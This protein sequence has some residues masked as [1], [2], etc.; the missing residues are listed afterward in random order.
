MQIICKICGNIFEACQYEVNRGRKFCSLKCFSLSQHKRIKKTCPSCKKIFEVP[1]CESERRKFCSIQCRKSY[2]GKQVF[3]ASC[4]KDFRVLNLILKMG[5]GKFCSQKCYDNYRTNETETKY[6]S[7][8]G[9]QYLSRKSQPR[10]F[11]SQQCYWDDLSNRKYPTN[12][13]LNQDRIVDILEEQGCLV[14]DIHHLG[15]GV[16]DILVLSKTGVF[17]FEIKNPD[18]RHKLTLAQKKFM[19]SWLGPVKIVTT[20]EQALEAVR[21]ERSR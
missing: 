2:Y 9:T 7:I 12:K 5:A 16:P 15:H 11:C 10:K 19:N 13:D 1:K 14:W 21:N 6:C 17:L 18:T 8:C 3:C 20:P 4:G